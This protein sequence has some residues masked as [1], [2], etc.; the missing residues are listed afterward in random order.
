MHVCVDSPQLPAVFERTEGDHLFAVEQDERVACEVERL[1][2][3]LEVAERIAVSPYSDRSYAI[4]S[5]ATAAASP[6]T[7]GLKQRRYD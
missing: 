7:G 5:P 6:G 4:T 1:P 3:R 2:F